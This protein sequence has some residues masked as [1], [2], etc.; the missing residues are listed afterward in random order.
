QTA[1]HF[2]QGIA[3]LVP[4]EKPLWPKALAEQARAV[5]AALAAQSGVATPEQVARTFKGARAD[6]VAALLL[7]LAS[8]GQA[9]EV[10]PGRFAAWPPRA[11]PHPR[12]PNGHPQRTFSAAGVTF[13]ASSAFGPSG[14]GGAAASCSSSTRRRPRYAGRPNGRHH[15]TP[16][17]PKGE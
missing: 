10:E 1:L 13:R 9:R 7:T 11:A 16:T 14:A 8:L 6:R 3:A 17:L 15:C 12:R 4:Q 5:Q 2:D